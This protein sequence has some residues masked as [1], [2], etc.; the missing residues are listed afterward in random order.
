M[1]IL[2]Y[3]CDVAMDSG[4]EPLAVWSA[5]QVRVVIIA[6]RQMIGGKSSSLFVFGDLF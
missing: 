3:A 4:E 6:G 2:D 1:R 5:I